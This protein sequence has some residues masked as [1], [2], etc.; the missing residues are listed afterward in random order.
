M[1]ASAF[2]SINGFSGPFVGI[3]SPYKPPSIDDENLDEQ[4]YLQ[5]YTAGNG[6]ALLI[7]IEDGSVWYWSH[8]EDEFDLLAKRFTI[9]VERATA[10]GCIGADCGLSGGR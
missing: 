1:D 6:D 3:A 9:Y 5:F 7:R 4:L 10:L 8:E 2:N